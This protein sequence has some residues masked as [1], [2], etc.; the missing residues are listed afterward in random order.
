MNTKTPSTSMHI[1]IDLQGAQASNRYRGIG[2]YS[3]ALALT[4]AQLARGKHRVSLMLNLT[5]AN[6]I[7]PIRLAFA[8][9]VA[10]Q[11]IHLWQPLNPC[12]SHGGGNTWRRGASEA[13]YTA[14]VRSLKADVLLI[15]SLFE[16]YGDDAII[17]IP[18][19]IDVPF[20]AVV[21]YDLIPY[22]HPKPY[23][24]NK[25]ISAWYHGR[26][27][28]ARRADLLLAISASSTK[29]AIDYLGIDKSQVVNISSAIDKR[30]RAISIDNIEEKKLL[31]KYGINRQFVMYT[32]GIDYRKNIEGLIAAY[33]TLPPSLRAHHQLA[34]VCSADE[35][36]R[37][38]LSDLA[39]R[40]SLT[41]DELVLT[42]FV[43]DD[44]LLALYNL[45]TLFV[46]P[47]W[48]EG[49]GLP[50][51]EAMACGAPT[52]A[53]NCSSLPEVI[54]W[55]DALFDP[56]DKSSIASAIE[57]VLTDVEFRTALKQHGLRQS[58]NFSWNVTAQRAL[59]ALETMSAER[60][61]A[62][63]IAK[64]QFST[65]EKPR[66]AYISPFQ[67]AQSG[68]SDYSAELLPVL[69]V[70]YDIDV[71][72]EQSEPLTDLWILGNAHQHSVAWFE[73]HAKQY[74]RVLYHLGNSHFHKH[75]FNLLERYPGVVV[76]HDFFLSGV[77]AYREVT[78]EVPGAWARELLHSHGWKA[79]RHRYEAEDAADCIYAWPCNLD[80]LQRAL[81]IIVHSEYS[82]QLTTQWYGS[83]Y[84]TDWAVIPLLRVPITNVRRTAARESLGL[85]ETDILVC[86]FGM[87]GK[88]KLNHRLLEAW[89][90]SCLAHDPHCQLV[91][92]GMASG[93]YGDQILEQISAS[94]SRIRITGWADEE[95]YR[96][97]LAAA[98]IAVQLRTLSRGETSAAA[99]D[100]MNYGIATIVNANGSM[101]EL[102][103]NAVWM[104]DDNF[105]TESLVKA[106][107]AL[108][109][110]PACRA[111]LGEQAHA[112]I[113]ER[114][115]PRACA[116]Q[117][118]HA[119]ERFYTKSEQGMLGLACRLSPLG[120]PLD[121]ADL[122]LLAE[123]AALIFPPRR[124][125][126]RQ[127]LLDISAFHGTD[128]KTGIQRVVRS[129]LHTLLTHSPEGFRVEP[130]Y[131][132][133]NHG[134]RYARRFT[135]RFLG[136]ADVGIEDTLIF[137]QAGDVF[138]GLDLQPSVV[139]LH[140]AELRSLRLRGVKVVFTVYDLLPI[141]RPEAF[142]LRPAEGYARW[143]C[144]LAT[145]SDGLI[146]ISE[147]GSKQLKQWLTLFGPQQGHALKIG[148]AHLGADIVELNTCNTAFY[149]TPEQSRLLNAISRYPA[150]LMVGTLE[151]R[152]AHL[153][154]LTAFEL[155]WSRGERINLV[156]VGKKGWL[157]DDLVVHLNNHPLRERHVFWLEQIDDIFLEQIY[158]SCSCLLAASLDEGYG[159]PL[160][161]AARHKL[162]I[163]ARD[164]AVFREVAGNYADYFSGTD[165]QALADSIDLWIRTNHVGTVAQSEGV[166]WMDWTQAIKGILAVILHDQWQ[167]SL[168]PIQDEKLMAR[169]WGSDPRLCS[170]VG[171][172]IG[173]KTWT[174][175]KAGY[176]LHGPYIDL[177]RGRYSVTLHGIIGPVGLYGAKMDICISGGREVLAIAQL[178]GKKQHDEQIIGTIE[179]T[180]TER[181]DDLEVRVEVGKF[182][183]FAVS[184]MEI[185]EIFYV[186]DLHPEKNKNTKTILPINNCSSYNEMPA[187]AYWATHPE[188]RSEVGYIDGRSIHTTGKSGFLIYGPYAKCPAGRYGI[189]IYADA[190]ETSGAWVGVCYDNGNKFISKQQLLLLNQSARQIDF[191]D[192]EFTLDKFV[193]DLEF[194]IYVDDHSRIR[195]DAF[196][197]EE[198]T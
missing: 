48:H 117:F 198:I 146:S 120:Q 34:V 37:K 98:D 1:L 106:L 159:L 12:F 79:L 147:E 72:V 169:Y 39:A 80:I 85:R 113:L 89:L 133:A 165:P 75:M 197:I 82:R 61:A 83:D 108:R 69:A 5:F 115:Q 177:K 64:V 76:L 151:P 28:H 143:L 180:L 123:R 179:F 134:Y 49:F 44:D 45:C 128:D 187:L 29:E 38:K 94:N 191:Y 70:H 47:S 41:S 43:S 153:Q 95:T 36:A 114:H 118:S 30:F 171:Y 156:I 194:V 175:G 102:P 105:S 119:I 16:G 2:R 157:V 27:S 26:L 77:Q 63:P 186:Q 22:I 195:V 149:P 46:F 181:C 54:G 91:F 4:L 58:Q 193:H 62:K 88:P 144:T 126:F 192:L 190:P 19:K 145:V 196:I 124:P 162:P 130:V 127:L 81:G 139:P 173:T 14:F 141:L 99:L 65:G 59:D 164:I 15:T 167:D 53:S 178:T 73:T 185:R 23:L 20:T 125:G 138:W 21:L 142:E 131:A 129:V 90:S 87:I 66:L 42:G 168:Q 9:V 170:I 51:L 136:L 188:L 161:E 100:C 60:K 13:L 172:L 122:S 132:T 84:G 174:S 7:D 40:H 104:I 33:A 56:L 17:A 110:D 137:A 74:D 150:F 109:Y 183:D 97:Y 93:D 166:R 155:L 25:S 103:H 111:E 176:L 8:D 50:A 158:V 121:V 116:A 6:T 32:G 154:A 68:I 189:K 184:M 11:D 140:E 3:E 107:E 24:E 112:S 135:T 148:W 96:Q 160:I 31:D 35:A 92:V 18:N 55:E 67:S 52:L 182:S 78:G 163:L 101:A 10:A 86:S 152:K 57:H 71:I